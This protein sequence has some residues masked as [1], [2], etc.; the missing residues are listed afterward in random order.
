MESSVDRH[1][2]TG[3]FASLESCVNSPGAVKWLIKDRVFDPGLIDQSSPGVFTSGCV[4][5]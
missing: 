1:R 2:V 3:V 4:I 5:Q